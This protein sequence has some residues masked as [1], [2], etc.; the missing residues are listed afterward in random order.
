MRC[1]SALPAALIVACQPRLALAQRQF[2][3]VLAGQEQGVEGEEDQVV[4]LA[5]RQ[6]RLQRREVGRAVVVQ[7]AGLAVVE[8]VGQRGGVLGDGA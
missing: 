7:G 6:R 1:S 5:V 2:A 8:A 4:G 3:Q